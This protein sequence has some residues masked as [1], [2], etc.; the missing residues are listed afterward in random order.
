MPGK[1]G[2]V[3][4]LVVLGIDSPCLPRDLPLRDGA[5]TRWLGPPQERLGMDSGSQTV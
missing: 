2:D 5:V 1:T 4:M 3:R